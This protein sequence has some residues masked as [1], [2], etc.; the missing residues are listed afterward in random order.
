M[1]RAVA[2]LAAAGAAAAG[3]PGSGHDRDGG[4]DRGAGSVGR[5]RPRDGAQIVHP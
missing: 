3:P 4:R 2:A 5:R 1:P